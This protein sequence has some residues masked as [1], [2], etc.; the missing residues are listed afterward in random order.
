MHQSV[1]AAQEFDESRAENVVE[2]CVDDGVEGRRHVSEPHKGGDEGVGEV[3]GP[4]HCRQ[5]VDGEERRPA[6]D[7]D[8][9]HHAQDLGGLLLRANRVVPPH[10]VVGG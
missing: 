7:E 6:N 5:D 2:N 3:A 9:K 10:A 1:A 8:H 4:A